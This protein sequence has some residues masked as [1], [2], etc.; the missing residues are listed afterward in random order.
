MLAAL[1]LAGCAGTAEPS[2]PRIADIIPYGPAWS[3]S[4]VQA[5]T[6]SP[7]QQAV[8]AAPA[9]PMGQSAT[10]TPYR[11]GFAAMDSVPPLPD[12]PKAKPGKSNVIK[13]QPK[14][15]IN[16]PKSETVHNKPGHASHA[17]R[18]KSTSGGLVSVHGYHRKNGTYVHSYH[19]HKP[20][21]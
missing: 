16:V 1:M 14:F 8:A 20:R 12:T 18:A 21:L 6:L 3:A 17:L 13:I 11:P 15:V 10:P 7:A 19:R 2:L 9:P 5:E 4:Q